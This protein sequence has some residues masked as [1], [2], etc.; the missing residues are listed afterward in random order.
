MNFNYS[1][2]SYSDNIYWLNFH[3]WYSPGL[4]CYDR[5]DVSEGTDINKRS[6]SKQCNIC[7]CGY[8]LDKA[9][10]PN[11]GG[12]EVILPPPPPPPFFGSLL[13]TQKW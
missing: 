3:I 7:H 13:I 6:A 8:F 10:K 5:I 11:L 9:F 4:L 1:L 2:P 12:G